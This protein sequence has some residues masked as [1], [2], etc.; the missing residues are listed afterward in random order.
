VDKIKFLEPESTAVTCDV[1][2][3]A[4][5]LELDR[6]KEAARELRR[7]MGWYESAADLSDVAAERLRADTWAAAHDRLARSYAAARA[8]AEREAAKN[9]ELTEKLEAAERRNGE[10]RTIIDNRKTIAESLAMVSAMTATDARDVLKGAERMLDVP[11]LRRRTNSA[12]ARVADLEARIVKACDGWSLELV[13]SKTGGGKS[14]SE[15][16]PAH[17]KTPHAARAW[18]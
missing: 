14:N 1:S 18:K 8:D 3:L 4:R 15:P 13:A 12:E 9:R 11:E 5:T 7:R 10:L 17:A 2:C 16:E 6:N